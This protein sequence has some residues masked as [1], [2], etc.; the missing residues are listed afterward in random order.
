MNPVPL[1][2]IIVTLPLLLGGCGEKPVVEVKP[3]EEKVLEVKEEVKTEEP[4]AETK[5]KPEGV[6]REELEQRESI[7]YLIGSDTPYT[8]KSFELYDNGQK[9]WEGNFKDGKADGLSVM[10]FENGQ[11][12]SEANFKDGKLAGLATTWHENGQKRNEVTFKDGTFVG[13]EVVW[14]ENG[15]KAQERNYKNGIIISDK[16]WNKKGEPVDSEE[17]AGLNNP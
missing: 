15:Q 9:R 7:W 13:L 16:F 17:E 8:G 5:P 2:L 11:K 3:V 10:W 1:F 12:E 6:N 4:L 14:H